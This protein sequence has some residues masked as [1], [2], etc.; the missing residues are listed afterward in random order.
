MNP[1]LVA[2]AVVAPAAPTLVGPSID[3]AA[4]SPLLIL[5]GGALVLL[6]AAALT[7]PWPRK[8]AALGAVAV[9]VAVI[10]V[11]I[12]QWRDV[13]EHGGRLLVANSLRLNHFSVWATVV[14]AIATAATILTT[15]DYLE[16]EGLRRIAPEV[17]GLYLVGAIGAVVMA[18]ANDLIV[19]FL[20]L[21]IMSLSFYVLVG[22]YRRRRQGQEASLKYFIL[23]G[24]FSAVFLYGVAMLYG[25]AGSTN[26]GRIVARFDVVLPVGKRE[27]LALAGVAMVLI[28]L[29]FKASLVPL[30]LWAPDVYQGAPT[31]VT[32]YLASVGKVGAFAAMLQVL[33]GAVPQWSGQYQPVVWALAVATLVVGA[34]LAVVQSDVKR[35]LA[36]SSI[37]HAGFMM[38]GVEAAAHL[39][40]AGFGE[41]ISSTLVY[42]ALYALLIVG[43]FAVVSVVSRRGDQ[44]TSVDSFRGLS[45]SHPWLAVA[46]TVLLVAQAGVQK[47]SVFV[48][49]IRV[50]SA[51]VHQRSYALAI[52]AMVSAVIAAFLDLRIM[53]NVWSSPEEG[54]EPA[55]ERAGVATTVVAT[56]CAL[57]AIGIGL[58]PG[59]LVDLAERIVR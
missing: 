10:V 55:A 49:K 34:V 51:A 56:V 41:G 12:C 17:Y 8:L 19:L 58:F 20:G 22:S 6:L 11:S 31:P 2:P 39:R 15:E 26:Y 18:A 14:I 24:A 59:W 9:C 54:D 43:T 16:R 57:V 27:T 37:S 47:T 36:Y 21:E 33:V 32:G 44:A 7:R 1:T 35:M 45:S 3:W 38:V 42:L 48:A 28:G 25:A 23:G 4:L 46:L 53:L 50:I 13:S 52:I 29:A 40:G 30:H 5:L